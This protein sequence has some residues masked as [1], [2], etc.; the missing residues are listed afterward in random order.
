MCM[1]QGCRLDGDQGDTPSRAYLT[2]LF[3]CETP[4]VHLPWN[5]DTD[6]YVLELMQREFMDIIVIR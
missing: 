5:L 1:R 3:N 4:P 6:Y 2:Q